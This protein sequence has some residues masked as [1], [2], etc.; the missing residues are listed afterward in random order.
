MAFNKKTDIDID[1]FDRDK[2][3]NVLPHVNASIIKNDTIRDHN[4]G[5][6]LQDIPTFMN[7]NMASLDYKEAS[8]HGFFK[9]DILNNTIYEYVESEQHLDTL[10]AT[11]PDWSLLI[12]DDIIPKLFQIHKYGYELKKWK[13]NSI[14]KLAMFIAMIRPAKKYL[15]DYS[16]WEDI[17]EEI[18]KKP[19]NNDS[20]YFKKSHSIAYANVIRIQLNLLSGF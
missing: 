16:N 13:P 1:I 19:D 9:L 2:A 14:M 8:K 7:Y 17:K 15:L 5:I 4:V 20:H 12:H 18:W 10:L 11:E 6:Y 3:L